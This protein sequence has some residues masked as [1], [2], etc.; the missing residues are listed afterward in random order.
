MALTLVNRY[1]R[2]YDQDVE[3]RETAHLKKLSG[4]EAAEL[5]R[6]ANRSREKI[7]VITRRLRNHPAASTLLNDGPSKGKISEIDPAQ[8]ANATRQILEIRW[9]IENTEP[10]RGLQGLADATKEWLE[11]AIA[12]F[13][14]MHEVTSLLKEDKAAAE[15]GVSTVSE[16][17][18][19]QQQSS[20]SLSSSFTSPYRTQVSPD[21]AGTGLSSGSRSPRIASTSLAAATTSTTRDEDATVGGTARSTVRMTGGSD[22][23]NSASASVPIIPPLAATSGPRAS[24]GISHAQGQPAAHQQRPL[25]EVISPGPEN[26]SPRRRSTVSRGTSPMP[27]ALLA[28]QA[29]SLAGAT[30]VE[31]GLESS[32]GSGPVD[33]AVDSQDGLESLPINS[34]DNSPPSPDSL[35]TSPIALP[36]PGQNRRHDSPEQP[37]P[38]SSPQ[39]RSPLGLMTVS[40]ATTGIVAGTHTSTPGNH[41]NEQQTQSGKE[42]SPENDE[43][44]EEETT[45]V[46][47]KRKRV[48]EYAFSDT[49]PVHDQPVLTEA[50][51]E[52]LKDQAQRTSK[53][54]SAEEVEVSFE[55]RVWMEGPV[56]PGAHDRPGAS[57]PAAVGPSRPPHSNSA[58]VAADQRLDE[59]LLQMMASAEQA[60]TSTPMPTFDTLK[61]DSQGSNDERRDMEDHERDITEFLSEQEEEDGL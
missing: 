45:T 41:P 34:D 37:I 19:G 7:R 20:T 17:G 60:P 53:I 59:M 6:T 22:G 40:T 29:G 9:T 28:E 30:Q 61:H 47:R 39:Q 35:P 31:K 52:R 3:C 26:V 33:D 12:R 46:T 13:Q 16:A 42:N 51:L 18:S 49:Q 43:T 8:R 24:D 32:S 11:C 1:L 14:F 4:A 15:V 38:S 48:I 25:D 10:A 23:R 2:N 21:G 50:L 57:S 55:Q 27:E 36:T 44:S 56:L 5:L 58:E 54:L